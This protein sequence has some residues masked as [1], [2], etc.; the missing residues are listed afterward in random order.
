M[1][2][3]IYSG[4]RLPVFESLLHYL[5]N[6]SIPQT[7]HLKSRVKIVPAMFSVKKKK[8]KRVPTVRVFERITIIKT[9]E[10]CRPV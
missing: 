3:N 1:V 10:I 2:K 5:G 4:A 6:L 9:Y 8:K 7:P